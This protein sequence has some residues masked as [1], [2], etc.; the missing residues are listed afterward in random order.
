MLAAQAAYLQASGTDNSL[1]ITLGGH[2]GW[3]LR[4]DGE[5]NRREDDPG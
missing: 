1:A 3:Y 4:N 5:G 2:L